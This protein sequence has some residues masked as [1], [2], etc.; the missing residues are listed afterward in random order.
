M[1]AMKKLAAWDCKEILQCAILA[2]K[3][4]LPRKHNV[5]VLNLLFELATWHG[6]AKLQMHTA[7]TL[8]DLDASL[9]RLGQDLRQ[10]KKITCATYV[11]LEL[12]AE[13]AAHGR[14]TAAL[15]TC[16]KSSAKQL[17]NDSAPTKWEPWTRDLS[18]VKLHSL[19]DY[20]DNICRHGT[21]DN[22]STQIVSF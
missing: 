10:F 17:A 2:F 18:T 14:Q 1:A 7:S 12:P 16:Q 11:T 13:V 3:H 5:I 4:L 22:Y 9:T 20:V 8:R 6:L 19:G 21:T 15:A